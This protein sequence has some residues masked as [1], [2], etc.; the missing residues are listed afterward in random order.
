[1]TH[2]QLQLGMNK[3]DLELEQ[4]MKSSEKACHKINRNNIEWSPQ[5]MVWIHR[6]WLLKRVQRYLDNKTRDPRNL[7]RDCLRR[8]V[9]NPL[10][11]TPEQLRTEF[12]VC[13]RN[14][15]LLTKNGP[16][17]YL[18]HLQELASR[19]SLQGDM[20]RAAKI[21][22]IIHKEAV[23]KQWNRINGSTRKARCSL[24]LLR[25]K[26]PLE[27]GGHE[28]YK[29]K[30]GLFAAVSPVLVER[31]Q[32]A[33]IAPCHHGSFFEDVGHLADGPVSQQILKAWLGI[34]FWDSVSWDY[35]NSEFRFRFRSSGTFRRKSKSENLKSVQVENRNSGTDF[36]GIPEFR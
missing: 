21:T 25:V 23:R 9:T 24:T 26:V 29:T 32:S 5:A 13:K 14:I 30:E 31:F 2:I 15:D 6:R 1:M 34:P 17:F 7:I 27:G 22:A 10:I 33:L 11:I 36:S 28:E 18:K 35:R 19:S 16:H 3:V 8:G 4:F 12:F 20:H